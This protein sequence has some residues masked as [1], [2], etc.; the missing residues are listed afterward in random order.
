MI[1]L[2]YVRVTSYSRFL[3]GEKGGVG[4]VVSGT[5]VLGSAMSLPQIEALPRFWTPQ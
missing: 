1:E 2:I 4:F 3:V 5:W